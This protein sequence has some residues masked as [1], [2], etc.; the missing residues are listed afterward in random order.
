MHRMLLLLDIG[1]NA[2]RNKFLKAIVVTKSQAWT[3]DNDFNDT[4]L[5]IIFILFR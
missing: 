1:W 2:K 3:R 5:Y 4:S